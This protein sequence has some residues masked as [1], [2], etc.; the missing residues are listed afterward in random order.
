MLTDRSFYGACFAAILAPAA[1]GVVLD[2][3][4]DVDLRVM[5]AIALVWFIVCVLVATWDDVRKKE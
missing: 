5:I 2:K 4:V 1:I 3:N